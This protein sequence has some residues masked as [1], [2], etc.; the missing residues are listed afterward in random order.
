[1]TSDGTST[2][3]WDAENRLVAV[4]EGASTVASYAYRQ[5]GIRA[6][7]T[8]AGVTTT[9]ILD[10]DNVVEARLGAGGVTKHFHGPEIDNV[11]GMQDAANEVTFLTRDHL[12]SVREHVNMAGAVTLRRDYDAWGNLTAGANT[13]G[14][15][16]TGRESDSETGL[17]YYRARYFSAGLA[18]FLGEDP[19]HLK[20][21]PNRYAYVEN[22][23]I[24]HIDPLGLD[25]VTA[26][27]TVR[28]CMCDLWKKAGYGFFKHERSAWVLKNEGGYSCLPWPWSAQ[29][30]RETWNGPIPSVQVGIVHTHPDALD[31]K[32]SRGGPPSDEKTA[33]Q[34]HQKV[35]TVSRKG[36]WS[37]DPQ[38]TIT[39]EEDSKWTKCCE[40]K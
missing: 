15:A 16:F 19:A 28:Q 21:G 6:S 10:G 27:S 23:P 2:Y 3:E 9:Y 39:P 4:K 24:T 13:S 8:V 1:M 31:P 7:K 12:G 22:R 17:Q 18:R 11:L 29:T 34:I 38:G 33:K 37:I 36:V 40:Q 30:A 35:Y 14:W 5:G 20:A 25:E 26:D 32:P